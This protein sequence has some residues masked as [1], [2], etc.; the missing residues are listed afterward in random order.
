M[1]MLNRKLGRDLWR[2]RGQALAVAAVI[3]SGLA[4]L[5]MSL[6]AVASLEETRAAFYERYRF[7]DVFAHARR[8]PAR[9][10]ARMAAIAG[11]RAVETRIVEQAL[12][13]IAGMAEPA[14]A[15]LVSVPEDRRPR[16][17][18]L[19]L[20]EG[21]WLR[22]GRPDEALVSEAFAE[23]HGYRPGDSLTAVIN[24][25][26]RHLTI[27]GIALSPEY[28]YILPPGQLMPD[29]RRFGVLWMGREAL[30]A[31][32]D[33][34]GAFNDVALKLS[35]GTESRAVIE[36]LDALLRPYGTTGAFGRD[37]QTSN[38]FLSGEIRQLR[39][40]AG[41][42]PAIFLA[43]A[44]F[45][46]NVAA[47]RLV[48]TERSQ[49]GLLKAF[50]FGNARIGWHYV[51]LMAAMAGL[52]VLLGWGAGALLGQ[53]I[54]GQY[55]QFFRF[56]FLIY[57][58]E[59][60][61]FAL[62]AAVGLAAAGFGAVTAVAQ[63]ARLAPAEAMQP[64]APPSYRRWRVG[65]AL[66]WMR[67]DQPTLMILR[68]IVRWPVRAGLTVLGVALAAAVLV[69]S[70]QWIDS[71]EVLLARQFFV[72]QRHDATVTFV[73][74]LGER[75]VRALEQ[76]PGVL[77]AEPFRSVA[78]R[79]RVGHLE[80]REALV[81]VPAA[82]GLT[83]RVDAGGRPLPLPPRGM[84][85]SQALADRLGVRPGDM[86]SVEVLEGRQPL[87]RLRVAAVAETYL[88]TPAWMDIDALRRALGEGATVSGAHLLI[89]SAQREAFYRRLK[90]T[91][92]VAGVVLRAAAIGMF[93]DTM[94]ETMYIMVGFFVALAG[95]LTF[96]VV[97]NSARIALS[98]RGRELASLRVLG[99]STGEVSYIL[100]GEL[101]V[102]TLLALPLGAL[103]GRG[104][105]E[106]MAGMME[107]E[108]YRLPVA[109]A[110]ATYGVAALVVLA[111]TALSAVAMARRLRRLD[112]VAALK[113][114]E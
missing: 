23:A 53:W 94:G 39:T 19:V 76:V 81:G 20:R 59:P 48:A 5:I 32:F 79:F 22:P 57:R 69:L 46:L 90:E 97:Y 92:M 30:A 74:A 101:A 8:A 6:G 110:P 33:L 40:M 51:K 89:D 102:L 58:P 80:R 16:L 62:A 82:A 66:S 83:Q 26:R 91:P 41:I 34:D 93:R 13:D 25:T 45:L 114:Y 37:D 99:F 4:M 2:M 70:L 24:G 10:Q 14:G 18:D 100:L 78:A 112:M 15:L 106:F 61:V 95:L 43:V 71:I 31:A 98:E 84:M 103:I 38:W 12:L 21:R 73:D 72:E 17:N 56:P 27:A 60:W 29:D 85:L 52:G 113:T 35:P 77:A 64:P 88:G 49:I 42:L 28:V 105:A 108:L 44:A 55:A 1:T 111:A 104:L 63:A 87:L 109:V 54:T 86:V 50:G 36:R 47:S 11:V 75:A 3:A 107:T 9:L 67:T 96:G 65:R 7:A 68:H